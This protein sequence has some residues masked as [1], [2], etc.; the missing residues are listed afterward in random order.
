MKRRE[1]IKFGA[2]AGMSLPIAGRGAAAQ[3]HDP[4][5]VDA[6]VF[7]LFIKP[8]DRLP[9]EEIIRLAA[10]AGYGGIDLTFRRKGHI[11]AAAG[12]KDLPRFVSLAQKAG[13][14]VPLAVT[15]IT[16]ASDPV[17]AETIRMLAAN[18]ITHYRMGVLKYDSAKSI[19]ANLEGFRV[20]MDR[21]CELNAKH[22][23]HGASQNHVGT[24][25][26]SSVWDVYQVINAMD[27]RYIGC[28]YDIRH[29]VAEG[30]QSWPLPFKAIGSHVK[31]TCIKDFTWE[32]QPDGKFKPVSVPLGEG[33]V[34]F[35]T[36]FR[37]LHEL[38]VQGPVSVHFEYKLL[39]GAAEQLPAA[40]R[41]PLLVSV[42]EKD[43]KLLDSM[44]HES[45]SPS[46]QR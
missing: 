24:N 41:M 11:E 46:P 37:L 2:I 10:A 9:S 30:M 16:D 44:A 8:F 7:C 1:F 23:V 33:I 43:R 39:S 22:G 19:A 32:K 25:F 31:S 36:Y 26:S 3:H 12:S 6:S 27:P 29:A 14:T 34:D 15:D 4:A 28:Q 40:Q 17:T 20:T 13:L 38:K 21:L 35:K 5:P 45:S 18:G 42:L